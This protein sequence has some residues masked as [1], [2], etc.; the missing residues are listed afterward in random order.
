MSKELSNGAEGANSNS[1]EGNE[2]GRNGSG[3]PNAG[4]AIGPMI[5]NINSPSVSLASVSSDGSTESYVVEPEEMFALTQEVKRLKEA[6]SRLRK[7]FHADMERTE[8]TKVATHERLG[9]VLKIL[10]QLLEKY[11]LLQSNELVGSAGRLIQK[12]KNYDYEDENSLDPK[13]FHEALDALALAFS[14]RVSEYIMGDLVKNTRYS[15]AIFL[16]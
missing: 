4:A 14:S 3:Q 12:V 7:V 16:K 13:D 5:G 1:M 11:P 8:T 15:S 2:S 6:L 10:R 9:E